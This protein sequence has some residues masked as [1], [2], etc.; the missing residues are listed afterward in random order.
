MSRGMDVGSVGERL[1][2]GLLIRVRIRWFP[3]KVR[4]RCFHCR[5]IWIDWK[6]KPCMR[7]HA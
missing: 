6:R 4:R 7:N 5:T 2:Q 1:S 3:E